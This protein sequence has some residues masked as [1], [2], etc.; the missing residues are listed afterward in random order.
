MPLAIVAA[1]SRVWCTLHDAK[2][3]WNV[4]NHIITEIIGSHASVFFLSCLDLPSSLSEEFFFWSNVMK[5]METKN[6]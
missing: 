1:S 5:R 6:K 2:K 4:H 3:A